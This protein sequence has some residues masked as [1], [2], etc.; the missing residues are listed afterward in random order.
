[1]AVTES[2]AIAGMVGVAPGRI[3]ATVGAGIWAWR[4]S[5]PA[6]PYFVE[7]PP[8]SAATAAR[9]THELPETD[10]GEAA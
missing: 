5:L 6:T 7:A 2:A 3:C 1:L 10:T 8:S 9:G 4:G